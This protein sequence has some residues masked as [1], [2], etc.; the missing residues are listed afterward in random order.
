MN[1]PGGVK[2]YVERYGPNMYAL[3]KQ[4]ADPRKWEGKVVEEVVKD[5]RALLPL[6]ELPDRCK[7]RNTR[8]MALVSHKLEQD[9]KDVKQ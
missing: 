4:Q 1:A 8:L 5:R 6:E 7:W 3:S 9:K 2:D